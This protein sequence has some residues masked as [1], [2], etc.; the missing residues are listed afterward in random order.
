MFSFNYGK[1][2]SFLAF[3]SILL[4]NTDISLKQTKWC[5]EVNIIL[6]QKDPPQISILMWIEKVHFMIKIFFWVYDI[7]DNATPCVISNGVKLYTPL[8]L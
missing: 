3:S 2:I 6:H 7:I 4:E 5:K 8:E 1:H